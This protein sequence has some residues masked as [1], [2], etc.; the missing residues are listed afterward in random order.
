MSLGADSTRTTEDM[1]D[2]YLERSSDCILSLLSI[3][4]IQK[5]EDENLVCVV[6]KNRL[7]YW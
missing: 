3:I 5:I 4:V 2:G 6:C 7:V 1:A